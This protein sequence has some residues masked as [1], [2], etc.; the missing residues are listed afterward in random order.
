MATHLLKNGI[1]KI[2][3]SQERFLILIGLLIGLLVIAPIIDQFVAIRFF[4]NLFL[5]LITAAML[6]FLQASKKQFYF[7]LLLAFVVL[8]SAWIQHVYSNTTIEALGMITGVVF[9][10]MLLKQLFDY[11]L[12]SIDVT[13]EVIYAA[14]LLYLMAA[15][16]WSFGYSFLFLVD[17]GS[18]HIPESYGMVN[19][20]TFQYFSIVTITT[21]GYGDILP[22]STVAK[23]FSSLEAFAGQ[24]YLV[25]VV[26]WLVGM[27]VSKKS[28]QEKENPK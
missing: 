23:A 13:R 9:C 26:A 12:E 22:V 14:I 3:G 11:I 21:L 28:G 20:L 24:I 27:H 18:F 25:I 17:H 16:M 8:L 1:K 19:L 5:T 7:S 10:W 6:N 15:L 4:L 2:S